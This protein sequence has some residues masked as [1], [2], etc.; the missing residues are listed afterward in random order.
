MAK[1][2]IGDTVVIKELDRMGRN[3]NEI[4]ENFE[5]IKS[6]GVFLSFRKSTLSTKENLKLK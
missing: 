3:N 1:L 6:K 5:L 4:K 2:I